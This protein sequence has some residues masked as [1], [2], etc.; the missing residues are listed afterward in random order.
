MPR[1][2]VRPVGMQPRPGSPA[3][4]PLGRRETGSAP[5]ASGSTAS[6]QCRPQ[7]RARR[8]ARGIRVPLDLD[9]YPD[10]LVAA[11][12]GLACAAGAS[13]PHFHPGS[14]SEVSP[15]A[16]ALGPA[17][18]DEHTIAILAEADRERVAS[19]AAPTG[20]RDQ[21]E[22][23]AQQRMK[24]RGEHC[25]HHGIGG[26]VE[27]RERRVTFGR[28]GDGIAASPARSAIPAEPAWRSLT[29]KVQRTG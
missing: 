21:R 2:H 22:A 26:A 11:G 10:A 8:S 1:K 25:P 19:P 24:R 18:V 17:D 16:L 28:G 5:T 7:A 20:D 23:A 3:F 27:H 4:G 12:H 15:P 9:R 29:R 6:R 13:D 14:A